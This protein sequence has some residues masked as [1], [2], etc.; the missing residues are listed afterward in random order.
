MLLGQV[1]TPDG[2]SWFMSMRS[3]GRGSDSLP[4]HVDT[5][6]SP[7]LWKLLSPSVHT[8]KVFG[9]SRNISV[10]STAF[11]NNQGSYQISPIPFTQ[12][13]KFLLTMSDATGF[14]T[15][16]TSELLTVGAPVGSTSCNTSSPSLAYSFSLPSSLQQCRYAE[17]L[18]PVYPRNLPRH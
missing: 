5:S 8:A 17:D 6:E 13:A 11:N 14:G 16:G 2:F 7:T 3:N 12:D 10:P 15:G 18:T 4:N 9:I 1:S